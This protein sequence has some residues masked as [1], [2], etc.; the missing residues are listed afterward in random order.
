M[1]HPQPPWAT[2][3]VRHHP[4]GEGDCHSW[5][6]AGSALS[7]QSSV[8][9]L[10]Q[11]EVLEVGGALPLTA[12]PPSAQGE[13]ILSQASAAPEEDSAEGSEEDTA[14]SAAEVGLP[15]TPRRPA[16]PPAAA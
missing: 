4:L 5:S 12:L 15:T 10:W 11:W 1:G 2:C 8:S 3:S 9:Q 16:G 13:E 6:R 7:W 14:D